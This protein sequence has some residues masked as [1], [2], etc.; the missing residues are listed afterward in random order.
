MS[1]E[2]PAILLIT[3]DQLRR[4]ALGCYGGRA[5]ATPNLDR[6]A[7]TGTVYEQAWSASP[8]CLP[9]RSSILT[10]RYPRNHRA[11][12]NFRD[13]PLSRDIPNIYTTLRGAGYHTAH[14]GKCHYAPVPYDQTRP[15]KTLPY[16]EFRDY[17]LSLGID[18][19][20]LQDDK[21]VSVWFQD[22]YATEL[23]AA[24][25]L[26]A[27]RA[28]VWNRDHRKVFTFP[29][30]TEWHP[31][32]WVGRNAVEHIQNHD[33]AKP[34]FLWASFSGPHFPFD[35]PAEYLDRVDENKLGDP[36]IAGDLDDPTRAH[37]RSRH[38]GNTHHWI[39]GGTG[40]HYSDEHWRKLRR[41]YAAN[42]ALIDDQ[43][44]QLLDAA[45]AR[46]GDNLLIAFTCDHGEMLG[47]HGVWGKG[48]CFYS[49]VLHL[50]FIVSHPHGAGAG[51]RSQRLSSQVD[52]YPTFA[53]AAGVD[54]SGQADPDPRAAVTPA[55]AP[56]DGKDLNHTGHEFVYAEGEG[57]L[58][59]TN[60]RH[61]LATIDKAGNRHTEFFDLD[62]DPNELENL[63]GHP[64]HA[65]AQRDLATAAMTALL[66]AALP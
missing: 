5:V 41:H 19:L 17:Y 24:G 36:L 60:G 43:I 26:E 64:K 27:Y 32:S 20:R 55:T 25:H 42:V 13:C 66:P 52:L 34:M 6:L 59:V 40:I 46:F 16:Q 12:S 62:A 58:T 11:Y 47:N 22:D 49:D 8:W 38:G 31:D 65:E 10:G 7:A 29:G 15:D 44:G 23:D 51:T 35:P 48:N 30:P 28:A 18:H 56:V 57:F 9:A 4:D 54:L 2:Q 50:P 14:V 33:D 21:Q 53:A 1:S 39:E 61:K 37:H 45:R 63:A 3:A